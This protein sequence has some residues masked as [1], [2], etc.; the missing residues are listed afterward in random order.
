MKVFVKTESVNINSSITLGYRYGI[1]FI[2][3]NNIGYSAIV[4]LGYKA[5]KLVEE[6]YTGSR[7]YTYS[8]IESGASWYCGATLTG[9]INGKITI[10]KFNPI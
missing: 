9:D 3:D 7:K 5:C 6:Q 2:S 1:Y 8:I 4:L 10:W